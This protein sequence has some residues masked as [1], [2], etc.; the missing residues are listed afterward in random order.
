MKAEELRIGNWVLSKGKPIQVDEIFKAPDGWHDISCTKETHDLLEEVTPIPLTDE[1]LLKAGFESYT[2]CYEKVY[3]DND[4]KYNVFRV[5]FND[6]GYWV[7]LEQKH[8]IDADGNITWIGLNMGTY[9]YL[10]QL[11]NLY[12]ALTGE[13]LEIKL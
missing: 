5:M 4:E 1:I 6:L 2:S 12:F 9:K 13:E 10:H 3:F 8:G 11:Q 7:I